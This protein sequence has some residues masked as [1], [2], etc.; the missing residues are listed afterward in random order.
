MYP[1]LLSGSW[2]RTVS[3]RH[4]KIFGERAIKEE[5]SMKNK[6][7]IFFVLCCFVLGGC[8]AIYEQRRN[9]RG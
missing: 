7:I 6:I 2:R 9:D 5:V 3:K 8:F 4:R 1:M